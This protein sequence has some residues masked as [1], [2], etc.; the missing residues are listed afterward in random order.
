MLKC[1]INYHNYHDCHDCHDNHDYHLTYLDLLPYDILNLIYKQK[2]KLDFN[3]VLRSLK[4]QLKPKPHYN[5]PQLTMYNKLYKNI[6]NYY[7]I[8]YYD[9]QFIPETVLYFIYFASENMGKKDCYRINNA[10]NNVNWKHNFNL[11][12]I[13]YDNQNRDNLDNL[14]IFLYILNYQELLSFKKFIN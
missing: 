3:D 9:I 5:Y 10:Y 4:I 13:Y 8:H 1:L 2:F 11:T 14:Q 6:I 7:N 12:N